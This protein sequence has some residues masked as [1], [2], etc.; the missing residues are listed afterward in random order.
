MTKDQILEELKKSGNETR[1][2]MYLKNG[3]SKNTYG[4]LLGDL[5]K[6]AK[7]IGPNHPLAMELWDSENT[8]A[9]WL[10]C[11][12]L[13]GKKLSIEQIRSMV[14][15]LT[16][17]DIIDKFIQEVVYYNEN[18]EV[19]MEEWIASTTDHEGR[20]GWQ[21]MVSNVSQGKMQVKELEELLATIEKKLQT[22]APKTQWAMNHVMCEIGIVY[23][24][25]TMRCIALGEKLGVYKELK[26]PKGC[27]S[28]YAPNWIGAIIKKRKV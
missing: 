6:L 17:P 18:A 8:D 10:A 2:N 11:M 13:D 12:L 4:V 28:A 1:R 27:T 24:D 21:L 23:P 9:R 19:L 22:A 5:R 3:A 20:A 7:Q 14:S 26:V 25:Y 15:N 16:Y